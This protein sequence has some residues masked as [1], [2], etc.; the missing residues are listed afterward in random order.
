MLCCESPATDRG[1]K[2]GHPEKCSNIRTTNGVIPFC[3]EQNY[4]NSIVTQIFLLS[5]KHQNHKLPM[6]ILNVPPRFLLPIFQLKNLHPQNPQNLWG[7]LTSQWCSQ[8][9][10]EQA[11]QGACARHG[12]G[13]IT[14]KPA[15]QLGFSNYVHQVVFF[16]DIFFF[17]KLSARKLGKM[18]NNLT[19]VFFQMGWNSRNH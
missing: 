8:F 18:I 6:F 2:R 16:F 5:S 10:G 17:L 14:L 11:P 4:R 13:L 12:C 3:W 15:N 19:N 9:G 7:P 1:C